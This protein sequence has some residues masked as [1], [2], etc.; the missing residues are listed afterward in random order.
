MIG[1]IPWIEF[2]A[3][4]GIPYQIHKLHDI[5]LETSCVQRIMDI[6]SWLIQFLVIEDYLRH[7][8]TQGFRC[9]DM[10]KNR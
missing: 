3:N 6:V 7:D 8:Q 9:L 2:A 5:A 10:K 4:N 1:W